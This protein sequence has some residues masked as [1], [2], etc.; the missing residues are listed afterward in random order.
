MSLSRSAVPTGLRLWLLA[1]RPKT[2]TLAVMPVLTGSAL[3]FSNTGILDPW[4]LLLTLLAA[5]GVQAGTNLYNDAADHGSGVDGAHRLG[6][7][8]ATAM[9]W[10]TPAAVR[11]AAHVSF[12]LAWGAGLYLIWRGGWFILLLAGLSTLA[13]YAYSAG[14]RP[15]AATPW[16]EVMVL[17]FFGVAAV[18]GTH[19]L[20]SGN[21]PVS[22]LVAGLVVG[23]PAAAV[24]LV[25]N[26]RDRVGDAAA[27]RR[28]LAILLGPE[29]TCRVYAVLVLLP[30][31][32]LVPLAWLTH[33]G[34]LAGGLALPLMMGCI[35][36]MKQANSGVAMNDLLASTARAQVLLGALMAVGWMVF[37]AAVGAAETVAREVDLESGKEINV[38]CAAC[39]GSQG[40]GSKNGEYPRLAG[41]RRGY[42]ERQLRSFKARGRHNLPMFP[43]ATE[44]ELPEAELQ[45][46]AAYLSGLEISVTIPPPE[47]GDAGRGAAL[48]RQN[49]R[50]CHGEGGEGNDERG[51][52]ALAEQYP[53]YLL[54]QITLF[55]NGGRVDERMHEQVEDVTAAEAQDIV[56]WLAGLE[57]H[58]GVAER[59]AR[60]TQ[61]QIQQILKGLMQPPAASP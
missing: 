1:V 12:L 29:R 49:C 32:L 5:L 14:P 41:Q 47:S 27:G 18:S 3:A 58:P 31:P 55:Q 36:R 57:R 42:L 30:L 34:V 21:I 15:I 56:A 6:P 22:A 52:P 26:H 28:T 61:D 24:L 37:A 8:R 20:Q 7:P 9:G 19:W 13:G 53:A 45:D 35:R 39:H 23:L 17:M 48:Y 38:T 60:E 16:G 2:L 25:N 54:R 44:R 33:P 51:A 4:P 10:A 50:R 11:R 40:Q 59:Q 43:Y 46:V